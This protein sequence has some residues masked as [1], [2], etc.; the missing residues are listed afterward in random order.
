MF[1]VKAV[2]TAVIGILVAQAWN[3]IHPAAAQVSNSTGAVC[4]SV[5][6]VAWQVPSLV[7]QYKLIAGLVI[8]LIC[9][10]ALLCFL[11]FIAIALA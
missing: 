7:P 1:I 11:L 3:H 8:G 9:F 10:V 2:I 6:S 5:S 4:G